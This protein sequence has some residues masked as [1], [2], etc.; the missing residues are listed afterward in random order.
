VQ[1]ESLGNKLRREQDKMEEG[2]V[3][4]LQ[5]WQLFTAMF[6]GFWA[7]SA[8][9]DHFL[10]TAVFCIAYGVVAEIMSNHL[11]GG[12]EIPTCELDAKKAELARLERQAMMEEMEERE[13]KDE[14]ERILNSNEAIWQKAEE[15]LN[16]EDEDDDDGPPP[17]PARDY[18]PPPLVSLLDPGED[19]MARSIYLEEQRMPTL[20]DVPDVREEHSVY[21][22]SMSDEFNQNTTSLDLNSANNG[23]IVEENG[24]G[25]EAGQ[26]G[27]LLHFDHSLTQS[28]VFQGGETLASQGDLMSDE[29]ARA[30]VN[31]VSSSEEDDEGDEALGDN[32]VFAPDSSDDEE[33]EVEREIQ[34][35]ESDSDSDSSEEAGAVDQEEFDFMRKQ[36]EKMVSLEDGPVSSPSDNEGKADSNSL[37]R[38]G[39]LSSS[40][41]E[42]KPVNVV[43]ASGKPTS[44]LFEESEDRSS[45]VDPQEGGRDEEQASSNIK[46]S[47]ELSSHVAELIPSSDLGEASNMEAGLPDNIQDFEEGKGRHHETPS[48]SSSSDSSP[49][50]DIDLTDPEVQA[51]AAKIQTAFKGFKSRKQQP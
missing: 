49:V 5:P 30:V 12:E 4:S 42:E 21:E 25:L 34:F 11:Y 13:A 38:V 29:V 41:G 19:V 31:G 37:Q 10:L 16:D 24:F 43:E 28:A 47:P 1:A 6:V 2:G 15:E 32:L 20:D 46:G 35:D 23:G 17:L 8:Y 7:T 18:A 36:E 48:L 26:Q 50:I 51:A 39:S 22:R 44:G 3:G 14:K 27:N 45:I 33:E 9:F 40:D